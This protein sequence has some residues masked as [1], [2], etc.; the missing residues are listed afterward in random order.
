M[1]TPSENQALRVLRRLG[2]VRA[3]ELEA[4]GIPRGQLYR[5]VRKGLVERQA[6]GIYVAG[7]HPITAQHTLAHVAKRVPGGIFCLLTALRF[8]ELTTQA[9]A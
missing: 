1:A 5:L 2:I 9:P 8:P 6:R 7:N 3:A 4:H